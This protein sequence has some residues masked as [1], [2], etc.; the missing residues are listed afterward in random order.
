[1]RYGIVNHKGNIIAKFKYEIDRDRCFYLFKLLEEDCARVI[2]K[3]G[4]VLE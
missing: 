4:G 3:D 1:M 2:I